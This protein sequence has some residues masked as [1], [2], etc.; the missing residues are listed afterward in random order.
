[1]QPDEKPRSISNVGC[2]PADHAGVDV[3][4]ADNDQRIGHV[5]LQVV[6]HERVRSDERARRLYL[7]QAA[8]WE[9]ALDVSPITPSADAAEKIRLMLT[10]FDDPGDGREEAVARLV[11]KLAQVR[12]EREEV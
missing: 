1:M 10:F 7:N 11:K 12:N 9:W 3:H 6:S 2:A 5:V 4:E 8:V